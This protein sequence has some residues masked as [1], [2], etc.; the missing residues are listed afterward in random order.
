[1]ITKAGITKAWIRNVC[2]ALLAAA[3]A[4]V[5]FVAAQSNPAP[6]VVRFKQ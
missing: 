1:M 4:C 6:L 2:A 5:S 3:G